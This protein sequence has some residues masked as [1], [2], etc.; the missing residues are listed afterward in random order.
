MPNYQEIVSP[1]YNYDLNLAIAGNE[2]LIFHCHHYNCYLQG[3]IEDTKSIIDPYPILI[4]SAEEVV[5]SYL[6]NLKTEYQL[7]NEDLLKT[8]LEHFKHSGYGLINT[9][10]LSSIEKGN[11]ELPYSHYAIGW[12]SKFGNRKEDLPGVC[13][14]ASGYLQALLAI[15]FEKDMGSYSV[16]ETDCHAKHNGNQSCHFEY[17]LRDKKLDLDESSQLGVTSS[18]LENK[19]NLDTNVDYEAIRQA[20]TNMPIIG[21]EIG[22]IDAFGV[23]LTRMFANYYCKISFKT[24]QALIDNAGDDG[25]QLGKELFTEAGQTCA[26]NTFGGIMTSAEWD[27]MIKPM[28]KTKEDWVHGIIAVV[29]ALGWGIYQVKELKPNKEF[30]MDVNGSYETNMLLSEYSEKDDPSCNF[31]RGAAAGIMNLIYNI[32]ISKKPTLDEN[33]YNT[34][35]KSSGMFIPEEE[36][37]CRVETKGNHC[38]FQ[39]SKNN[40]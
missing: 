30:I 1:Q 8:A 2:P 39:V 12:K 36:E 40:G 9:P 35:F 20:L 34:V 21:N 10:N 7:T 5:F 27:A 31:N 25:R 29:N 16:S 19:Y 32:D 17:K 6:K 26:F 13:F 23:M 18:G 4:N 38:E 15:Y 3:T 22:M 11:F 33:L 28:L 14:F 37:C 24:L